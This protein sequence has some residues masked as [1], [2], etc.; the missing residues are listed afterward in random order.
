MQQPTSADIRVLDGFLHTLCDGRRIASAEIARVAVELWPMRQRRQPVY[1]AIGETTLAVFLREPKV[2][3]Q[4][5]CFMV[6]PLTWEL[7]S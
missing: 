3:K 7:W 2:L 4:S 5:H 1:V 6:V